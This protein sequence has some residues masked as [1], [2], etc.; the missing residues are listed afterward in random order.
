MSDT[1]PSATVL[2]PGARRGLGRPERS[3]EDDDKFA[4]SAVAEVG[5][6]LRGRVER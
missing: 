2:P 3:G 5:Q 6:S 1:I 4:D